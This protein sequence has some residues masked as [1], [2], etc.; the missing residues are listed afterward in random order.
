M[1]NYRSSIPKIAKERVIATFV[2]NPRKYKAEYILNG[3]VVGV[4]QFYETGE[5]E[6]EWALKNGL[7]HGIAYRCDVPGK[8]LSA[9]P[10]SHGLPHGTAKQFSSDGELIGT[11]AMKQGTG[12]DL[13]WDESGDNDFRQLS[14]ARYLKD[15]KW[16]GFE[17]WLNADQESVWSERHFQD[18]RQHG[19]ERSWN[20]RGRLDRGYPRYWVNGE[21]VTKR[22]YLRECC[23]DSS[24]PRFREEDNRPVRKFPREVK[25]VKA[26]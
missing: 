26:R 2:N 24:L 19:I 25:V 9:E 15:G 1:K 14:E 8:V 20:S 6:S 10:Y 16:H 22:K 5:L 18:N 4:R 3:E 21:R 12:I 13:W 17:W 23:H 11:Y 7:M